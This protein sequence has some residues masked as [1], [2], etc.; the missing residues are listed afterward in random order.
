MVRK[1]RIAQW[2]FDTGPILGRFH[3]WLEDI[4]V[5]WIRGENHRNLDLSISF[6]DD[7][8]ERLFTMTA[9]VTSLSII[10]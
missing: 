7:R 9:A 2:A 10:W 8:I 4:E 3:I 5:E 1:D 6:V